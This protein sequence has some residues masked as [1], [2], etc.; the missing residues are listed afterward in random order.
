[1]VPL[2]YRLKAFVVDMFMIMMPIMYI[3]TYIVFGTKEQMQANDT[4]HW[5]TAGVFGV[6]VVLFWLLKGQTP[7]MKAYDI[8]VVDNTNKQNISLAQAVNR[9]LIFILTAITIVLLFVPFFKKNKKMLHDTMT[10]SS[11]VVDITANQTN[12]TNKK[13]NK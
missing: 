6:I 2:S 9:Y 1:M 3:T 11:V 8:K 13:D 4:A 5:A 7:G 10:N 12:Q